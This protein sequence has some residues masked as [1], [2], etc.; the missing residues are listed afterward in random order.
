MGT[1][2]TTASAAVV[3]V[4]ASKARG[5][6]ITVT[7]PFIGIDGQVHDIMAVAAAGRETW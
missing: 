3:A 1:A 7:M 5:V 4:A 2:T 6:R